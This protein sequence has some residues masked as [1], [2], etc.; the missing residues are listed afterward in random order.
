M[1]CASVVLPRDHARG[2]GFELHPSLNVEKKMKK[3]RKPWEGMLGCTWSK[4]GTS[5]RWWD[6]WDGLSIEERGRLE[7]EQEYRDNLA[8]ED[9][10][11]DLEY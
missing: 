2:V 1:R 9:K 6:V 8:T 11:H 4:S 5:R 10:L 7:Q 3:R